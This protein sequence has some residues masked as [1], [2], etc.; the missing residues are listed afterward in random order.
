MFRLPRL[1]LRVKCPLAIVGAALATGL[2]VG[3]AGLFAASKALTAEAEQRLLATATAT[4][5]ALSLYLESEVADIAVLAANPTVSG[6][7]TDLGNAFY[8]E[9]AKPTK[10]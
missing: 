10:W 8:L 6:A 7:L 5:R 2:A 9:S 4:S 3:A 1:S